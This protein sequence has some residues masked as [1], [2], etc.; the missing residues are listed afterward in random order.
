YARY[1]MWNF[2]GR[3]NDQQGHGN[4][5]DGNWI[6]GISFIDQMRLGGQNALPDSQKN[7]PSRNTYFFLP[8]ILGLLGAFWHF[9]YNQ[10]DA[11]IAG[12]LFFF[13]GLAIVFFLNQNPMQPRERD[14]AFA[15]SFY[16]FAILIG[17]GVV[18][19]SDFIKKKANPKTAATAGPVV[20]FLAAS[21]CIGWRNSDDRNRSARTTAR[22]LAINCLGSCAPTAILLAYGDPD[23]YPLWYAQEVE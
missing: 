7:N 6:S 2:A 10:K 8:L 18:A 23:T 20:R 21:I 19:I 13:T 14:Y 5:T 12:L 3:Q 22:D 1:F 15:G 17:F 4:F 16:A 9:K 11:G